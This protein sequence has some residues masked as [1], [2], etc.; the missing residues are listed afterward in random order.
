[1]VIRL[2]VSADL[3][4]TF[5]FSII[6]SKEEEAEEFLVGYSGSLNLQGLVSFTQI[7]DMNS[8]YLSSVQSLSRVRLF[9]TP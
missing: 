3:S 7:W 9:V 2:S 8:L 1:M 6:P 5:S 4:A